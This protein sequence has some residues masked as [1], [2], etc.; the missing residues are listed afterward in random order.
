MPKVTWLEYRHLS[1]ISHYAI[2]AAGAFSCLLHVSTLEKFY[3]ELHL[4]AAFEVVS[5]LQDKQI[6]RNHKKRNSEFY[7]DKA[8]L[9][10]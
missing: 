8:E 4:T 10:S 6:N 2:L 9:Q 5:Y 3:L 7:V 1:V